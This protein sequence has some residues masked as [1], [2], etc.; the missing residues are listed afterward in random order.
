M[1]KDEALLTAHEVMLFISR[2]PNLYEHITTELDLSDEAWELLMQA[3]EV[4]DG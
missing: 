3:L 4:N 1:D 2:Y